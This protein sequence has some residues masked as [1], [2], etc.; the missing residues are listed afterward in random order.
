MVSD[1][2]QEQTYSARTELLGCSDTG[3]DEDSEGL[4]REIEETE[5]VRLKAG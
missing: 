5:D 3:N 2:M 4:H 1:G